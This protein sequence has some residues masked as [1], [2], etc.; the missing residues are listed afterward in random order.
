MQRVAHGH[1]G[2]AIEGAQQDE[3]AEHPEGGFQQ[4]AK[5]RPAALLHHLLERGHQAGATALDGKA[6]QQRQDHARQQDHALPSAIRVI[7][8]A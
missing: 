5:A 8:Q 2:Q 7:R 6:H 3:A 4:G 1:L